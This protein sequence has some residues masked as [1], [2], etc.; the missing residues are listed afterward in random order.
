MQLSRTKFS[1][2][3]YLIKISFNQGVVNNFMSLMK[4]LATGIKFIL[5]SQGRVAIHRNEIIQ[6]YKTQLKLNKI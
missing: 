1:F 3:E 4:H 5:Y 2:N 6:L